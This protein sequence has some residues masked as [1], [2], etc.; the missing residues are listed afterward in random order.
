MWQL[1]KTTPI[2]CH[3]AASL[4]ITEDYFSFIPMTEVLYFTRYLKFQLT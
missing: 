2:S 3:I 1:M 4:V